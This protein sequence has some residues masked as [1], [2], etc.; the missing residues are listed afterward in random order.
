M[1]NCCIGHTTRIQWRKMVIELRDGC[2]GDNI[3]WSPVDL[4]NSTQGYW[5]VRDWLFT[6]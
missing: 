3:Y 2:E 1:W 4:H 5:P 6:G